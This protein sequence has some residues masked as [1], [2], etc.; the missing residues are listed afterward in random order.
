[1]L[2]QI[3]SQRLKVESKIVETKEFA[4]PAIAN[5]AK[6]S[7]KNIIQARKKPP[8]IK[9]ARWFF[10]VPKGKV[11]NVVKRNAEKI[12]SHPSVSVKSIDCVVN[13]SGRGATPLMNEI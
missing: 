4:T 8:N 10:N 12:I 9:L 11:R 6:Q 5:A 13:E 7:S 2:Q 3:F 1:L